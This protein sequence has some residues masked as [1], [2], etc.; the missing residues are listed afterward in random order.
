LLARVLD[1]SVHGPLFGTQGESVESE[2]EGELRRKRNGRGD[3]GSSTG[4][5]GRSSAVRW[6]KWNWPRDP[7]LANHQGSVP[8]KCL[9]GE[10]RRGIKRGI[11][12]GTDNVFGVSEV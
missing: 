2:G 1:L 6:G 4:S 5:K 10:G 12:D 9:G 8:V 3:L 11:V 7:E